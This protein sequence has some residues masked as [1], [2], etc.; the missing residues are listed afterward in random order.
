MTY[1]IKFNVV[2]IYLQDLANGLFSK[3]PMMALIL[4]SVKAKS[5]VNGL[6]IGIGGLLISDAIDSFLKAPAKKVRT[7]YFYVTL[8]NNIRE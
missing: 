3:K 7:V 5:F 1:Q 8:S 4:Q 6:T 2:V